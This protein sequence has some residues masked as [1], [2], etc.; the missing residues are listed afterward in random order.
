MGG[1]LF[2][3]QRLLRVQNDGC[4]AVNE[5]RFSLGEVESLNKVTAFVLGKI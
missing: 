4:C 5:G 1:G 2:D 3:G